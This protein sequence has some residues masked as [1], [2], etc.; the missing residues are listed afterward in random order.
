MSKAP[1]GLEQQEQRQ[2]TYMESFKKETTIWEILKSQNICRNKEVKFH[3]I[4]IPRIQNHKSKIDE[5]IL[6]N[7]T[8]LISSTTSN[9]A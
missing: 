6:L 3:I 2:T 9:N 5:A 7:D 1:K 4:K 8:F